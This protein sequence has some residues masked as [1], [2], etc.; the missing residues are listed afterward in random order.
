MTHSV[1]GVVDNVFTK[2][3]TSRN[4]KN[5]TINYVEVDGVVFSTGFNKKFE[6]GE[7]IDVQVE[8]K[9]N[10]WQYVSDGGGNLP[11]AGAT[12][13]KKPAPVKGNFGGN[14]GVFPIDPKDGQMSI[15][16]QSSMNRAVEIMEQLMNHDV[17]PIKTQEEYMTHLTNIA[18]E[19][20][21]FSSGNDITKLMQ[22]RIAAKE[23]A[24]G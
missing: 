21:D 22:A 6:E 3:K 9:Y 1:K 7:L 13:I 18:L 5:F 24:N 4:N 20:T 10:E 12:P 11:P 8:N 16:R 14:K 17:L 2:T 15:I 19:I 23:V